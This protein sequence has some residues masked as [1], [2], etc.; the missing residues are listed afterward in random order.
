MK[1]LI[2]VIIP[3]FNGAQY[4]AE[5]IESVL[6][7]DYPA[8]E[9][10]AVNDGSTDDSA[11]VLQGFGE[12]IRIVSQTNRGLGASRN[13]GIAVARGE[14]L[15]FLD[16]D[17]WWEPTKLSQQMAYW[18]EA[19]T[20]PLVFGLVQQFACPTLPAA[21][22]AQLL[23]NERLM[24][25]YFAGTLLLSRRRFEEVG[26]FIEVKQV[27][28]FIEWYSRAMERG[29][30]VVLLNQLATHRRIHQHNMGRQPD[31]YARTDYLKILKAHLV[32]QRRG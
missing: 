1:A 23:I 13:A 27:G 29:I 16:H 32:R 7:Q 26:P 31:L 19:K 24:P 22:R 28:E 9:I 20:D 25:G 12:R 14:L 8:V 18:Q 2:S 21:E 3:V 10:I 11:R 5:A 6:A 30:P 15:A 4:V 17:D